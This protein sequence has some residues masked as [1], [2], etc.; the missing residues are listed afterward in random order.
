MLP[1]TDC[2]V[3]NSNRILTFPTRKSV[4]IRQNMVVDGQYAAHELP[5]GDLSL[6]ACEN[7]GFVF[8]LLNPNGHEEVLKL[9]RG[10][11]LN[12]QSLDLTDVVEKNI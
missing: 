1:R 8:N 10:Q 3:C 6:V 12:V 11:G 5:G 7:C 4:P 9:I 2:P